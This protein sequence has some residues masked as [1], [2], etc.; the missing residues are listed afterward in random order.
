MNR[1]V[2]SLSSIGG[3]GRGEEAVRSLGFEVSTA[4]SW[5]IRQCLAEGL[6][7]NRLIGYRN[8]EP[9]SLLESD[10]GRFSFNGLQ[11]PEKEP[12]T[13]NLDIKAVAG[14]CGWQ[15]HPLFVV[16][17][18]CHGGIILLQKV[19]FKFQNRNSFA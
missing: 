15:D 14:L 4:R 19:F 2:F 16:G 8:R 1:L 12:F 18:N 10:L 3:E 5:K 9:A 7:V 11:L 6:L 17:Y 13:G